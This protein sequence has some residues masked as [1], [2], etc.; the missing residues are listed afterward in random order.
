MELEKIYL[1]NPIGDKYLSPDEIAARITRN[2]ALVALKKPTERSIEEAL[3]ED[4]KTQELIQ[5]GIFKK[6]KN[7]TQFLIPASY[8]VTFDSLHK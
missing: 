3:E 6:V 8:S 5:F 2:N 4:N 7:Y 1:D